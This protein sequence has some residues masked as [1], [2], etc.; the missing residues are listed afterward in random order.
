MG[1]CKDV[2][3]ARRAEA[4]DVPRVGMDYKRVTEQGVSSKGEKDEE[5]PGITM[6]VLK[7]QWQ[8]SIWVYPV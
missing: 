2:Y 3:H 6:L 1:R 7:D 4:L 5:R 8:K